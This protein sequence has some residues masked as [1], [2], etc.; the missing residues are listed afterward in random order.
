MNEVSTG[1]NTM[2]FLFEGNDVRVVIGEHGEPWF[3]AQDVCDC[4]EHTDTSKAVSRLDDDEKLVRT[5]FGA[6]QNRHLLTVN[7]SGL[8]NLILTSRKPEAKRMKKWVTSEVLPSIRKTGSYSLQPKPMSQIEVLLASV[9]MLADVEKRQLE[10]EQQQQQVQQNLAQQ[11][12]KLLQIDN[13]ITT[14]LEEVKETNLLTSCPSAAESITSIRLRMNEEYGL[15]ASVVDAVMR[16]SLYAPK[17]VGMVRN[18]HESSGGSTY[19]VYW[20]KDISNVF[21]MFVG[22]CKQV[23]ITLY[24]HPFIKGK[25]KLNK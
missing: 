6:G 9:Q 13:K 19:A 12:T 16:Q 7:E 23:S 11:K 5:L 17:P 25:F 21:K 4:L 8:F 3:V 15:S 20:K 24:K 2:A 18:Q 22:E 1:S 10:L 14:G